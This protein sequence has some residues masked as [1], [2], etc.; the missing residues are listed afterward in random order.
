[1]HIVTHTARANPYK[2]PVRQAISQS[3]IAAADSV[4]GESPLVMGVSTQGTIM[5]HVPHLAVMG[6]FGA[7]ENNL[8]APNEN[9]PVDRFPVPNPQSPI[10][11]LLP[12]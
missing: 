1:M 10:P 12:A 11:I 5:I 6:G 8:H 3:I 4:F 7:A 2:T 9:M